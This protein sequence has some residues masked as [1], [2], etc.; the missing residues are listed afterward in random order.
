MDI[1]AKEKDD[2]LRKVVNPPN[3][4]ARYTP[5][6][7]Y[8]ASIVDELRRDGMI[9]VRGDYALC[10]ITPKGRNH[11]DN[12]GYTAI[13]SEKKE[14]AALEMKR[15]KLDVRNGEWENRRYW[16]TTSIAIIAIIVSIVALFVSLH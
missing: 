13:E 7:E 15:L 3:N 9:T 8:V 1:L 4:N 11:L 10:S 12:G 2:I 5:D 16:I 6:G 14:A